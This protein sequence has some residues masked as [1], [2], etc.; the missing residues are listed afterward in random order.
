MLSFQMILCYEPIEHN[1]WLSLIVN[2]II[3][4]LYVKN[5]IYINIYIF[6][7]LYI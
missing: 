5:I 2:K 1:I 7:I 6:I 3:T 4:A